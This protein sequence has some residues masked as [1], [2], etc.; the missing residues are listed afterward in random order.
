[1]KIL[2]ISVTAL[3]G[4]ASLVLIYYALNGLDIPSTAIF[5]WLGACFLCPFMGIEWFK[6]P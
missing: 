4:L 3:C 5:A 2:S 1:M 6:S